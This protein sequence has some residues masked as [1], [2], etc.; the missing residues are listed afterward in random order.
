[1]SKIGERIAKLLA[2]TESP[3]E[4]EAKAALLK[5][6]ELMAEHKLRPE[7]IHQTSKAKVIVRRIGVTCTT[8]TDTWAVPLSGVI[9]KRYCCKAYR[10]HRKGKKRV[11]IGFAG[12]Q[13]DFEVCA[14]I[15]RYAYDCVK[16][17]CQEI[18]KEHQPMGYSAAELR[19]MCNAYGYGFTV[20]LR[21]AFDEQQKEHQEWGLVMVVPQAVEDATA[22]HKPA[23]AYGTFRTDGWC[24]AYAN[25]GYSEGKAFDV[26]HR[27]AP[28]GASGCKAVAGRQEQGAQYRLSVQMLPEKYQKVQELL[29]LEDFAQITPE[30]RLELGVC[31]DSETE[32]L[33]ASYPDGTE[34]ALLLCSGQNNYYLMSVLHAQGESAPVELQEYIAHTF[35]RWMCFDVRG[36]RYTMEIQIAEDS[37]HSMEPAGA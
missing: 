28:T 31:E 17:R 23:A 29:S 19:E 7:D 14:Y 12:L 4:H 21:D 34:I 9:A 20:G 1:M 13:D 25:T 24:S 30:R 27:I 37:D 32:L 26:D 16:K 18:R 8:M 11:E 36:N 15:Y 22:S 2:L 33:R 10:T 6:R 35:L 3:N 5:A